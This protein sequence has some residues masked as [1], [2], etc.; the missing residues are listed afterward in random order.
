MEHRCV[1][2]TLLHR[3][4]QYGIGIIHLFLRLPRRSIYCYQSM[5]S[6]A[7]FQ[8]AVSHET[9]VSIKYSSAVKPVNHPADITEIQMAKR[10]RGMTSAAF[11]DVDRN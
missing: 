3:Y 2:T 5:F 9:S 1:Y 6:F 10:Y 11:S 7:S 4:L 8:P